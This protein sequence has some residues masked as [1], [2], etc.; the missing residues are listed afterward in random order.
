L[1]LPQEVTFP[2][3][4]IFYADQIDYS[5]DGTIVYIPEW[6]WVEIS[7]YQLDVKKTE[8]QYKLFRE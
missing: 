7:L 6:L 8:E 2:E 5:E 3:F 4:P 1:V